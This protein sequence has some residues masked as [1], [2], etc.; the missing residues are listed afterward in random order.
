M[1]FVGAPDADSKYKSI[2]NSRKLWQFYSSFV[3]VRRAAFLW[4]AGQ[5]LTFEMILNL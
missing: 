4:L 3:S 1:F 5:F 2:D